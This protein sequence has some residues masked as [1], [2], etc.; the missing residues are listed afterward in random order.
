[1]L[2]QAILAAL[3]A[4]DICPPEI[5]ALDLG[6]DRPWVMVKNLCGR[7]LA[8]TDYTVRMGLA[9]WGE[10]AT[11]WYGLLKPGSCF[12]FH[13]D[14]PPQPTS[15]CAV[16]V[17]LFYYCDD[18]LTDPPMTSVL[19][20]DGADCGVEADHAVP[21]VWWSAEAWTCGSTFGLP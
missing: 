10:H 14:D 20:G 9:S 5:V 7:D 13:L 19:A 21:A 12:T 11:T 4:S 2:I 17:S 16:G 6:A 18:A 8:I 3:L 15:E 1:M